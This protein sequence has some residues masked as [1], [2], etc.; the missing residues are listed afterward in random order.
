MTD[1]N[2]SLMCDFYSL[3]MANALI[4]SGKGEEY[5]YFDVFFRRVPD[6][7]GYAVF[8]GLE[9]I[10]EFVKNIHFSSDD[11]RFL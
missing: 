4:E 9:D 2:L 8:A 11:L 1:T 6:K 5:V 10:I 3:T 7:G